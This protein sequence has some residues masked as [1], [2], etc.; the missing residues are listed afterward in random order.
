MSFRKHT[1]RYKVWIFAPHLETDDPNLQYY[2]DFTQSIAEFTKVFTEIRCEWEWVNVTLNNLGEVIARVKSHT[3]KHNIVLNLCDGDEIND[4]PGISVI[5]ALDEHQITYTGSD[6]YFYGITTSKIT[7]KKAFSEHGVSMPGWVKLNGHVD[8]NLFSKVGNPI[9]VKPA[10]SAG[11]MGL[12]VKNVVSN[13][14]ELKSI[15]TAMHEGYHGWKLDEAGLLAEQYIA[16]REFTTLLVGSFCHPDDITFYQPVE[17]VFHPSLPEK[18]KFLSFGRLW[19]IYDEESPMPDNGY[20][21]VYDHVTC[22]DLTRRLRELS[23]HAFHAVQGKGYA[24]LDI[25]MDKDTEQLYVLEINAQC[26]L[27]EDEDYTSIGAILKASNK[28]FT[29]LIVEVLDDA[30]LRSPS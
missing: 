24:R 19:E 20:L 25:R 23:L 4:V 8:K 5:R 15:L 18:E 29:D 3:G 28:T 10:I 22:P 30:L 1:A 7:M 11:S 26:G 17:R 14:G 16:G 27:S 12:T 13:V 9:I 21:Y 2:Y 6:A